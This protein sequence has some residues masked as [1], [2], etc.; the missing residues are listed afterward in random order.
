MIVVLVPL[1]QLYDLGQRQSTVPDES[2]LQLR[3]RCVGSVPIVW[4]NT[5]AGVV[6][7]VTGNLREN[8]KCIARILQV[9]EGNVARGEC[10]RLSCRAVGR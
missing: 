1:Q 6:L 7:A 5:Q 8:S 3:R 4:R 9:V 2:V 10:R